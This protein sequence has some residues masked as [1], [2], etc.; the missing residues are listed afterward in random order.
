MNAVREQEV[1]AGAEAKKKE[2][3]AE[4]EKHLREKIELEDLRK[5]KVQ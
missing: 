3:K 1:K 2:E 4:M 5:L